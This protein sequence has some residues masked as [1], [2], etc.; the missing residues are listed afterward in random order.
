MAGTLIRQ[1]YD[2]TAHH[3]SIGSPPNPFSILASAFGEIPVS[4]LEQ[5]YGEDLT[6]LTIS[7]L[8]G[9][10]TKNMA[11]NLHQRLVSIDHWLFVACPI[12]KT[13]DIS[14]RVTFDSFIE[15][16]MCDRVAP[17]AAPRYV[18]QTQQER[19]SVFHE[20]TL[21]AKFNIPA[22]KVQERNGGNIQYATQAVNTMRKELVMKY[23]AIES[24][25]VLTAQ[26]QIMHALMQCKL[27]KI[28]AERFYRPYRGF[29]NL[30]N[31]SM[32]LVGIITRFE[33]GA[34]NLISMVKDMRTKSSI[35]NDGLFM[36]I[37]ETTARMIISADKSRV[38]YNRAGPEA[39]TNKDMTAY[40]I[41]SIGDVPIY[42]QEDWSPYN[43]EGA[44]QLQPLENEMEVGRSYY[45]DPIQGR[46]KGDVRQRRSFEFLNLSGNVSRKLQDIRDAISADVNFDPDTGDLRRSALESFA[47]NYPQ[48]FSEQGIHYIQDRKGR[49]LIHPYLAPD[50]NNKFKV[51]DVIGGM[52]DAYLPQKYQKIFN[53]NTLDVLKESIGET[54]IRRIKRLNDIIKKASLLS[55]DNATVTNFITQNRRLNAYKRP[56]EDRNEF[57]VDDLLVFPERGNDDELR[58]FD[59]PPGYGSFPHMVYL[60]N[61]YLNTPYNDWIRYQKSQVVNKKWEEVHLGVEAVKEAFNFFSQAQ[62]SPVAINLAINPEGAPPQYMPNNSNSFNRDYLRQLYAFF[63]NCFEHTFLALYAR[64]AETVEVVENQYVLK[65]RTENKAVNELFTLLINNPYLSPVVRQTLIHEGKTT[66]EK[67]EREVFKNKADLKIEQKIQDSWFLGLLT[68]EVSQN[69]SLR[70]VLNTVNDDDQRVGAIL[71]STLINSL[72]DM[73]TPFPTNITGIYNESVKRKGLIKKTPIKEI[74]EPAKLNSRKR[75]YLSTVNNY[76]LEGVDNLNGYVMIPYQVS[77]ESTLTDR[78]KL[79]PPYY[80]R[81]ERAER[82]RNNTEDQGPAD[83]SRL[84]VNSESNA[85]GA[86]RQRAHGGVGFTGIQNYYDDDTGRAIP[87]SA[88]LPAVPFGL[89]PQALESKWF[90]NNLREVLNSVSQDCITKAINIMFL[91]TRIH[92]SVLEAMLTNNID[93]PVG[94]AFFD[95]FVNFTMQGAMFCQPNVGVCEHD[96]SDMGFTVD[97]SHNSLE[98]RK[99]FVMG[100]TIARS[101]AVQYIPNVMYQSYNS[102]GTGNLIRTFRSSTRGSN[103]HQVDFDYTD[104]RNRRGDRF[105]VSTAGVKMEEF[106]D[107]LSVSGELDVTSI[108]P[109]GNDLLTKDDTESFN[110]EMVPGLAFMRY[111]TGLQNLN[112]GLA[113]DKDGIYSGESTKQ[114]FRNHVNTLCSK[115]VQFQ[116]V[117][118]SGSF[119]TPINGNFGFLSPFKEGDGPSI[120]GGMKLLEEGYTVRI[121][122]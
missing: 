98:A 35:N 90:L 88:R 75:E 77:N 101:E 108:A 37:S 82:L 20:Y 96:L 39:V 10:S 91:S 46:Y 74:V 22:I 41:G 118:S 42:I 3:T 60:S 29:P 89:Q 28:F 34:N 87:R 76:D 19:L 18:V 4:K 23:A 13:D 80:G 51:V 72:N 106:P 59:L 84:A 63:N 26:V 50:E 44:D 15:P 48:I 112:K 100:V 65:Q 79:A 45:S 25:V 53:R 30:F 92:A 36:V 24:S 52:M 11:S 105:V 83:E 66:Y 103:N 33:K 122:H 102:G 85:S 119:S 70:E 14:T 71:F 32:L 58:N 1:P 97:N 7:N 67:L 113:R 68:K 64:D 57:G 86:K 115:A 17:F 47:H 73:S 21:G 62:S 99:G 55:L 78:F 121:A 104:P 27:P 120:N 111:V 110:R 61:I 93:I 16:T 12:V 69:V 95:P 109:Y 43:Y 8:F 116:W 56:Q 94:Y 49:P 5:A 114:Y 9:G 54:N 2:V 81:R 107:H 38:E 6:V 117:E 40:N 31:F